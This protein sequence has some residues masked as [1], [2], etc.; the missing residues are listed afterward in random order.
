MASQSLELPSCNG[1]AQIIIGP[2][3]RTEKN[4]AVG[5]VQKVKK[6]QKP[7]GCPKL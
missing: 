3:G 2:T 4:E 5:G 7:R 1:N 6:I